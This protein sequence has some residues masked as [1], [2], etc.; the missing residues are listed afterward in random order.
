MKE[1]HVMINMKYHFQFDI[2]NYKGNYLY[3][4]VYIYY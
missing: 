1:L 2:N 3:Y 4:L